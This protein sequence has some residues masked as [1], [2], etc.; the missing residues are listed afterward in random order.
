MSNSLLTA[1]TARFAIDQRRE[2]I[3]I[4]PDVRERL[5]RLLLQPEMRGVGYSSF[6]D[7]ACTLAE[8][9][10]ESRRRENET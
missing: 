8:E 5:K 4:H 1:N 9:E 7:Q 2:P 3:N 10:I 6:I